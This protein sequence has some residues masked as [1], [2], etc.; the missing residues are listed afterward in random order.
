MSYEHDWNGFGKVLRPPFRKYI[1]CGG[2]L[3]YIFV[4][5]EK[6][7]FSQTLNTLKMAEI[8]TSKMTSKK[9]FLKTPRGYFLSSV[10]QSNH[11]SSVLSQW[12]LFLMIRAFDRW[13]LENHMASQKCFTE[14]N[15]KL[16][17]SQKVKG[18]TSKCLQNPA[19]LEMRVFLHQVKIFLAAFK[20]L[21]NDL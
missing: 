14:G 15:Q 16:W 5:I 8:L 17:F 1:H 12:K 10:T 2:Y 7:K 18:E 20:C 19:D 11:I 6:R 4:K 13:Q 21:K 9:G 3:W